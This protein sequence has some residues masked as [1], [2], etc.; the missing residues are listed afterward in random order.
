LLEAI[1]AMAIAAV[2]V[3]GAVAEARNAVALAGATR[4]RALALSAA[5]EVIET[6]VGTPCGPAPRCPEDLT[7]DLRRSPFG[8]VAGVP[9]FLA[10]V[11]VRSA[12]GSIGV[13]ATLRAIGR[14]DCP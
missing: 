1:V 9:L 7:C 8:T 2:V 3:G 4:R 5:E 6:A 10:S 12:V 13:L 14:A 11:S